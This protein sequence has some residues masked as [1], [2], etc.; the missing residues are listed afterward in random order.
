MTDDAAAFGA[1]LRACRQAAGLSQEEL[2]GRSGLSIR[3][4][5]NLERGRTRW[6]YRDSVHRLADAM[7]LRDAPRAEFIAA[8]ARRV[9][10]GGP[11]A[12]AWPAARETDRP[13]PGRI[14][15][16]QLPAPVPAFVGRGDQ[17]A[18]LS[19]V[20]HDP[21][22][23]AVITAIG[24]T[25]GVGKTAL[26]VHWAHQVAAEF[27]DGQL[28][29]NLRGFDPS[30]P[31]LAESDAL[32][33]LLDALGVPADQLPQMLDAQL[34]LYRS[35]LAGK[36]MLVLLDNAHDVAQVRS[37]LPGS[38]TCRVVV[39]SRRQLTGL[40]AIE[41]AHPLTLDVLTGAEARQLLER[42]LGAGRIAAD[43]G[44]AER[45]AVSCARLPLALCVIA[46][47]AA[48][49]PDLPLARLAADLAG[50]P[51]LDAFSDGGDPA[52]DVRVVFSWSYR[53]LDANAA[54]A[55]RLA[56]LCPGPG[57]DRHQAAALTGTGAGQ[58]GELLETLARACLIQ[59]KG[60]DRYGLHD[61]LRDYARE[62]AGAQ[63]S[64]PERRAALTG[65][66]DYYLYGAAT[67]MDAAFPAEH[68][69][70]PAVPPSPVP[71]PVFTAAGA[72]LTWLATERSSLVACAAYAAEHGWPGHATRLSAILFR[73]LDTGGYHPEA[74]AIHGSA[75]LAAR[76]L[77]DRVAEADA[78]I[79]LGLADGQQDRYR[80][81]AGYFEQAL[82]LYRATGDQSGQARALNYLG[83][84][85]AQQDRYP[86]AISS[87]QE[88]AARYRALRDPQGEAYALG[89]LGMATLRDHGYEQA[90]G[91]HQRAL[92]LFRELGDRHGEASIL[93]RLGLVE[94][95]LERYQPAADHL[96]QALVQYREVGD[97]QGE[98]G[99][100]T[101]L[102]LIDLR[103]E[104]YQPAAH[105]FREALTRYREAGDP[106]GQ[107][108]S[109][110]GLGDV[111]V[112]TGRSGD[113]RAHYAAALDQATRAGERSEQAR[114]HDG[115]AATYRASGVPG[116]ARRH[117]AV[118][119][120]L[121][122]ELAGPGAAHPEL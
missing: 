77:G 60:P 3:A 12:R 56:G 86:A 84:T 89:N 49:T 14:V 32:R 15:P 25:A 1:R 120:A 99:V 39:T 115:L 82:A 95:R 109:L 20:L 108:A 24:G 107:A 68:H 38:L 42:R 21:G 17:L 4:I 113:A 11:V 104:R 75:R 112:A 46:A 103:R 7:G 101:R 88:A 55:F 117:Q 22:G 78:L 106:S 58:A 91:H 48:M 50:Q 85:E 57:L 73:Y 64:E 122:A 37:L 31:P 18:A 51:G 43:P 65:L 94:L 111:L 100:L 63:D 41:A 23:T 72:A 5:S 96:E 6:P 83:L 70:R 116:R 110:N 87:F 19:R 8:A 121:Y 44:A 79:G 35:L 67:A 45:I 28:F 71:P 92:A 74:A 52:A 29:V 69:R 97:R 10:R 119:H 47:R 53:Q 105:R 118:A 34:G 33:E 30:A 59:P 16:R 36:R 90:A 27:P 62:L 81:A 98:A 114:A 93:G 61:L 9:D 66:L 54:R 102:G 40:T 13:G 2:A 26:A 80:D 76:Q